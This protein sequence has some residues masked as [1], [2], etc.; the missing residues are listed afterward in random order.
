MLAAREGHPDIV[1][2]LVDKGADINIKDKNGRTA[3]MWAIENGHSDVVQ[4]FK[5]KSG[6]GELLVK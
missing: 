2:I 4:V 5:E 1:R 3:L 6:A